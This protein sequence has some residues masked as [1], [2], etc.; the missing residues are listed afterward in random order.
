MSLHVHRNTTTQNN[1]VFGVF[2]FYK[3]KLQ[4]YCFFF[5]TN[6]N[7]KNN[8]NNGPALLYQMPLIQAL[9]TF[10]EIEFQQ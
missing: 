3:N 1:P 2:A 8:K 7:K 5:F 9:L 10:P 6:N 4:N